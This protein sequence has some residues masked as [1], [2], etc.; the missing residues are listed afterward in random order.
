RTAAR[1]SHRARRRPGCSRRAARSTRPPRAR[2]R[3]S[4]VV[5]CGSLQP[6]LIR[7][8]STSPYRPTRVYPKLRASHALVALLALVP[9]AYLVRICVLLTIDVPLSDAWAMV[10]RLDHLYSGRLTFDDFWAQ[11]N[12]HRPA[13]PIAVM[14]AV[15]RLTRWDARWEIVV[16]LAVGVAI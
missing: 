14:L 13:V 9:F 1:W 16:N 11:H 7:V 2:P 8:L 6:F 15:A 4:A 3:E 10:P 12:E 5:H